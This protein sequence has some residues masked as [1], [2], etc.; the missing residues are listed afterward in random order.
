[1]T[2]PTMG[3]FNDSDGDEGYHSY[4]ND[5]ETNPVLVERKKR[6]EKRRRE[7]MQLVLTGMQAISILCSLYHYFFNLE[8]TKSIPHLIRRSFILLFTLTSFILWLISRLQLGTMLTF[9]AKA[10]GMLITTGIY[11][12]FRHP[13]YYFGS[14]SLFFFILLIEK[15]H[16]LFIFLVLIPFQIIRAF[17]ENRVLK[18]RFE[19]DYHDYIKKLWF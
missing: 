5:Y 12:K 9:Q 6:R 13:I 10:G 16:F 1:M 14:L 18:D 15:Y 2:K 7:L 4:N 3:R 11:S 8:R 17:Q 19:E